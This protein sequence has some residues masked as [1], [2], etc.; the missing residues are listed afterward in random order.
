MMQLTVIL[1]ICISNTLHQYTTYIFVCFFIWIKM[2]ILLLLI[3]DI[4][5]TNHYSSPQILVRLMF[6]DSDNREF[7]SVCIHI[8]ACF[9]LVFTFLLWLSAS[10]IRPVLCL[11]CLGILMGASVFLGASCFCETNQPLCFVFCVLMGVEGYIT[12]LYNIYLNFQWCN[13]FECH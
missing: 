12:I 5:G 11:C 4:P 8:N 1:S 7:E 9:I 6:F 10:C 2:I 13:I 3:L